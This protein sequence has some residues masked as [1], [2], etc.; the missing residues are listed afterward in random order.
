MLFDDGQIKVHIAAPTVAV[1]ATIHQPAYRRR[2]TA[3]PVARSTWIFAARSRAIAP[4]SRSRQGMFTANQPP[5]LSLPPLNFHIGGNSYTAPGVG[6]GAES[7]GGGGGCGCSGGAHYVLTQPISPAQVYPPDSV[8][9]L[10]NTLPGA[11]TGLS[12]AAPQP[13]SLAQSV[14]DFAMGLPSSYHLSA[15]G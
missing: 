14:Y 3:K 13:I 12:D 11:N 15:I 6:N 9:Y 8:P 4:G 7:Y 2:Q 10:G 5:S 1:A